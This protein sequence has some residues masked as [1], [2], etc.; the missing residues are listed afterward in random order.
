M[1]Y[2]KSFSYS[3]FWW[4]QLDS[5]I[6]DLSYNCVERSVTNRHPPIALLVSFTTSVVE[7]LHGSCPVW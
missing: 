4:P 6:E 3:Y 5:Q 7:D 1:S 2:M